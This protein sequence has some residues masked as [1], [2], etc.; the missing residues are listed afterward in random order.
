ML[1]ANPEKATTPE[2]AKEVE[3]ANMAWPDNKEDTQAITFFCWLK[4]KMIRR[5]YYEVL[6]EAVN[7]R[8]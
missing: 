6:I 7:S 8:P 2:F 3:L 4:S 1:L 5:P